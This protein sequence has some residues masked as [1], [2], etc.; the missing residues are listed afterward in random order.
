[1]KLSLR[2]RASCFQL[3]CFEAGTEGQGSASA[4]FLHLPLPRTDKSSNLAA[5]IYAGILA[6]GL[7]EEVD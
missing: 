5:E 2:L 3:K 6:L 4:A 7:R 1:M